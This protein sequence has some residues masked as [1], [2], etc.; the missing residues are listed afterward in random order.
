LINALQINLPGHTGE[1][2]S[3]WTWCERNDSFEVTHQSCKIQSTA[4]VLSNRD[5]GRD[6]SMHSAPSACSTI[7]M[8]HVHVLILRAQLEGRYEC[9]IRKSSARED[10][11]K[12]SERDRASDRYGK[13]R[14]G[15]TRMRCDA[16]HDGKR[17]AGS[18]R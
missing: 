15:S 1:S 13:S 2:S 4:L 3:M 17:N 12:D 9:K 16:G 5:R 14:D 10:L 8:W 18:R 7:G 11:I 6:F